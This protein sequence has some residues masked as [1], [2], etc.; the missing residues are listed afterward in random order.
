[1]SDTP[2]RSRPSLLTINRA[3][4]EQAPRGGAPEQPK[5]CIRVFPGLRGVETIEAYDHD[6]T[7]MIRVDVRADLADAQL[8]HGIDAWRRRHSSVR[9]RLMP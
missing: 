7:V 4:W 3:F 1:M 6:G 2:P 9:P 5:D 8:E